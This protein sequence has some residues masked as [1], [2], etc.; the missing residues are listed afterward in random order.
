M[1][2]I[3]V[4]I[5]VLLVLA[6]ATVSADNLSGIWTAGNG[7]FTVTFGANGS[8][9]AVCSDQEY[10]TLCTGGGELVETGTFTTSGSTLSITISSSNA[11]NKDM[12][13]GSPMII[14]FNANGSTVTFGNAAKLTFDWASGTSIEM[15]QKTTAVENRSWRAVKELFR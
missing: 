11:P 13:I 1:K 5:T 9:R 8:Y 15:V 14:P 6:A 3:A 7:D 2:Q 10:C 12:R 4:I